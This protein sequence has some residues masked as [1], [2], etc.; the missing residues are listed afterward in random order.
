[1]I[2]HNCVL[3]EIN[4]QLQTYLAQEPEALACPCQQC[5]NDIIALAANR[6]PARYTAS[7]EGRLLAGF[8]LQSKQV[9][10]DV[11]K[12]IIQATRQVNSAPRHDPHRQ[13]TP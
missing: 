1:M 10:L 9:Q 6:L 5:R 11:F 7:T 13:I 2:V 3:D 4:R 8:E 12:V